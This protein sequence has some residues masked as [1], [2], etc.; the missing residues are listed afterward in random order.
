MRRGFR[1][2]CGSPLFFVNGASRCVVLMYA[3][4]LGEPGWYRHGRD[5]FVRSAPAWD[6]MHPDLLKSDGMPGRP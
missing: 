3:G 2:D 1:G 6:L 4:S 5:N